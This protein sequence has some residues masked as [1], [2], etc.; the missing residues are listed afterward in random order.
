MKQKYS[1]PVY[2]PVVYAMLVLTCGGC[3]SVSNSPTPRFYMLPAVDGKLTNQTFK[4]ASNVIIGVSPVKIPE[5]L[6]RPQ[7]VTQDKDRLLTF[8]QFD[9]WGEPLDMALTRLTMKNLSIMLPQATIERFPGNP[10]VP[11][12][13]QV[14]MDVLQLESR[15]DQDLV[16]A[17]QWSI[18]DAPKKKMMLIKKSEFRPP[19]NPPAY[20]G[21]AKALGAANAALS[22][23]I[24]AA[25]AALASQPE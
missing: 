9:R 2:R 12:K 11:V 20:S 4:I 16:F 17:A 10:A 23:E 24:A 8:A 13:Y 25:L 18:I 6:N 19:I 14:N 21:L 22:A 7:I 5:Y 15:L 3:L 1:A